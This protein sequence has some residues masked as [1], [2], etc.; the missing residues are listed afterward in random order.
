MAVKKGKPT[1]FPLF[2]QKDVDNEVDGFVDEQEQKFVK[3][4]Q[5]VG[6]SFVNEARNLRTYRDVTGN[7]RSSTGY[8]VAVDSQIKTEDTGGGDDPTPKGTSKA[9]SLSHR[10]AKGKGLVLV[11]V[12][13]ME[14]GSAVEA[15]G[16]DVITG[17]TKNA[18]KLLK[19]LI[20][21][22]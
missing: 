8:V 12:A 7:L 4:L 16:R 19:E 18:E 6:E 9:K 13:G 14:Y 21:A 3:V 15:R 2:R 11:G 1:L 5:Y 10:L 22:I 17:P 20:A